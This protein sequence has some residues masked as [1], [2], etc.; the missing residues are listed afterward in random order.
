MKLL[1]GLM[2]LTIC[3]TALPAQETAQS[4]LRPYNSEAVRSECSTKWGAQFDMVHYCISQRQDGY[5][6]TRAIHQTMPDHF[7]MTFTHC[8]QEWAHQWDMVAYCLRQQSD[9][10]VEARAIY[11]T[12]PEAT[13]NKIFE[14]C[15]QKWDPQWDM[16]AYCMSR[17]AE[18]WKRLR[19]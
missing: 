6:D 17:Q 19:N 2:A 4:Q 3:G 18:A 12:L 16:I 9:G 13:G 10:L 7:Q 8:E 15:G 5:Q 1:S 14:H 11:K